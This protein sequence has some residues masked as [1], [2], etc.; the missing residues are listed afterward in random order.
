MKKTTILQLIGTLDFGGAQSL[1]LSQ[2]KNIDRNKYRIKVATILR[3]GALAPSFERLGFPV[4]NLGMHGKLDPRI[5]TRLYH[6]IKSE[7]VDIIHTHTFP[8]DFFGR[9]VGW[10]MRYPIIVTTVHNIGKLRAGY[11]LR[12]DRALS[13]ANDLIIACSEKVKEVLI[14]QGIR[15][16]KIQVICNGVDVEEINSRCPASITGRTPVLLSKASITGG[17]PVPLSVVGV[18]GS[19]LP[20][21]GHSYFIQA[22]KEVSRELPGVR[23]VIVGDGLLRGELEALTEKLGLSP[24]VNFTGFREDVLNLMAGF[25]LLVL[26]SLAEGFGIVLAEAMALS[27]PVVASRVGGIEEIVVDGETGILVPPAQPG[28]LSRAIIQA[29]R[30]GKKASEMGRKGYQ[31]VK[32][33]FDIKTKVRELEGAYERLMAKRAVR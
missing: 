9:M 4:I 19:L 31:R 27:K 1:L 33:R 20:I 29:L 18:V 30:D 14:S 21:K 6:L 7:Q 32:A 2:L 3:P 15:E 17:T 16:D 26:P 5:F 8:A 25:D 24:R 11:S 10:A 23:F 22:A 12:I 28:E 13:G